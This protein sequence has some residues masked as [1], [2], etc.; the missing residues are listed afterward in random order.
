ME[1]SKWLYANVVYN[2]GASYS[3]RGYR[4]TRGVPQNVTVKAIADSVRGVNGFHVRDVFEQPKEPEAQP[5]KTVKK[6]TVK[7]V[8]KK[9]VA[10]KASVF[11]D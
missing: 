10:K 9:K 1:D 6:K 2:A 3:I 7:K 11:E 8:A 4:F 5:K